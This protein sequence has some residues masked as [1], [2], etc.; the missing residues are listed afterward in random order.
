MFESRLG[1]TRNI[2]DGYIDLVITPFPDIRL[3][4]YNIYSCSVLRRDATLSVKRFEISLEIGIPT[5][6]GR[7]DTPLWRGVYYHGV[8]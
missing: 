7:E 3:G 1:L 6:C 5:V 8:A 4:A 2:K